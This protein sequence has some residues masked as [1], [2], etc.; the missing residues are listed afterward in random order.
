MVKFMMRSRVSP[1]AMCLIAL[2]TLL[3]ST[4]VVIVAGC[5][6]AHLDRSQSHEEHHGKQGSPGLDSLCAWACQANTDTGVAIGL[7]PTVTEMLASQADLIPYLC[8]RLAQLPNVPTR[9]PPPPP[10][11]RLG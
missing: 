7:A 11:V 4:L 3:Y 6:S 5:A 10:F 2:V 1:H 9:A 8:I